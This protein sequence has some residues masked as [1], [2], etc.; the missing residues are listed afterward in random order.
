MV[1]LTTIRSGT[2]RL[3]AEKQA[4]ICMGAAPGA[5][6]HRLDAHGGPSLAAA[7]RVKQRLAAAAAP[8]LR[9]GGWRE[10]LVT[11]DAGQRLHHGLQA[12]R[13]CITDRVD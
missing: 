12:C 6:L 11:R 5:R 9:H 13:N 3:R 1:A 10:Q 7:Q 4:G 8:Q 2:M